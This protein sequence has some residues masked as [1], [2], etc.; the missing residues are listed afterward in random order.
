MTRNLPLS[1]ISGFLGSG[2]TSLLNHMLSHAQDR[3]ITALVNDFGALN[4]DA[5]L[6]AAQNGNQLELANGCVCCSIGDDLMQTLAAIMRAPTRPD[7]IVIEASGVADPARIAAYAAIDPELR[8]DGIVTLVDASAHDLHGQ[9][10]YLADNY[11]R[12]IEAAHLLV[13]SKPD[14]LDAPKLAELEA[15]LTAQC[16]HV[17]VLQ[18]AH[19]VL[20]AELL[21]GLKGSAPEARPLDTHGL[22]SHALHIHGETD[23]LAVREKLLSLRPHLIRAKGIL[24]DKDG[25]YVIHFA[26]GRV[27]MEPFD[28]AP[29]GHLVLIGKPGLP[30]GAL[31]DALLQYFEEA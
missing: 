17:P 24:A 13:I 6:I 18:A 16:P 21:L 11:A 10:P 27:T 3:R 22:E 8:L 29:S 14:L 15:E 25:P 9:D 4:I 12:Q 30:N 1:I 28:A 23:R 31:L 5:E 7:H 2:K 20:P 26:A 19:G